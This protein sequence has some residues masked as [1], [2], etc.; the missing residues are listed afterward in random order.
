MSAWSIDIVQAMK[1]LESLPLPMQMRIAAEVIIRA[2]G[3]YVK[4]R[5][6]RRTVWSA[7]SLRELA[8][9]WQEED[10]QKAA[11]EA[12]TEEL[13]GFLAARIRGYSE[14]E[15]GLRAKPNIWHDCARELLDAGWRK[16]EG[17]S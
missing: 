1:S 3:E 8:N 16:T 6:H 10:A 17:A 7:D 14:E 4:R 11:K 5:D 12:E 2:N 15:W 9:E 13:A